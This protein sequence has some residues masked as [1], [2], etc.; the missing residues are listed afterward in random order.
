MAK[1]G[2]TK[3][4]FDSVVEKKGPYGWISKR[5]MAYTEGLVHTQ[6]T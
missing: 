3:A 6:K 2:L 5:M 1:N 4:T